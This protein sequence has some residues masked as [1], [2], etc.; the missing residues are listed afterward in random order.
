M[1][2]TEIQKDICDFYSRLM[3]TQEIVKWNSL[4]AWWNLWPIM[5]AYIYSVYWKWIDIEVLLK[6][7]LSDTI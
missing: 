1:E 6:N 7:D 5:S 3:Q 4:S 2:N